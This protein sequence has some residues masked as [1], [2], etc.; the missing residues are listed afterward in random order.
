VQ[1]FSGFETAAHKRFCVAAGA[2]LPR[3]KGDGAELYYLDHASRLMA[4]TVHT[5]GTEL[6][7]EAPRPLFHF[8]SAPQTWN[9][10]DV[11]PD[12][13]RFLVNLPLEWSDSSA[14]SIVTD[15]NRRLKR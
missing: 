8:Q 1:P 7:F 3:W 6:T 15:W 10:Y 13:Q 2:A 5:R 4:V 14:I 11:S 12:G 9:L